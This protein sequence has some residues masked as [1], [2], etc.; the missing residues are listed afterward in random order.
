MTYNEALEEFAFRY[1]LWARDEARLEVEH[2]Y[3]WLKRMDDEDCRKHLRRMAQL[4]IEEQQAFTALFVRSR[5]DPRA[6]ERA[7][8][9]PLSSED[10]ARRN[11]YYDSL[12]F[13]FDPVQQAFLRRQLHGDPT[14]KLDRRRFR[15]I[16]KEC[17]API[18]GKEDRGGGGGWWFYTTSVEGLRVITDVDTGGTVH[19][20]SYS[21]G[22]LFSEREPLREGI[23]VLQWLGLIGGSTC[24]SQI[25][26]SKAEETAHFLAELCD[27]FLKA[28]P[29]LLEGLAP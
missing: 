4:P 27:H 28:A 23:S 16:V 1:Y 20:L 11:R 9:V 8:D 17:L 5:H 3:P 13:E 29:K 19:Q 14:T 24:W 12:A 6:V 10:I 25:E 22:I 7:G 18:F 15:K 2:G 26:D 21:H